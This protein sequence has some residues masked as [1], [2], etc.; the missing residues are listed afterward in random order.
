MRVEGTAVSQPSRMEREKENMRAVEEKR[1]QEQATRNAESKSKD[2]VR[3]SAPP[4]PENK[5]KRVD[6]TA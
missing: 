3:P 2:F 5:G 4:L 1:M 6:T